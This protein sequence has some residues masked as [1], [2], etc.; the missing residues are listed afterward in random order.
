MVN[1]LLSWMR[2]DLDSR[3][4]SEKEEI[5][6]FMKDISHNNYH[7]QASILKQEIDSEIGGDYLDEA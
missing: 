6:T 4:R 1:S 2:K 7:M 5:V 3:L